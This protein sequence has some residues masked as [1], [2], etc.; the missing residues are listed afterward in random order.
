MTVR[1]RRRG[2]RPRRGQPKRPKRWSASSS[3]MVTDPSPGLVPV[4]VVDAL[5]LGDAGQPPV[6]MIL[7]GE[8]DVEDWADEQEIRVDRVVGD[9]AIAGNATQVGAPWSPICVRMGLIVVEELSDDGTAPDPTRNLFDQS[10]LQEAEWMWLH[11]TI[12]TAPTERMTSNVIPYAYNM[13]LDL[14]VRRKIGQKDG[15]FLYAAWAAETNAYDG[16]MVV[17]LRLYHHLRTIMVSK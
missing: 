3:F 8:F 6:D 12:L 10:D 5:A 2:F 11:Q 15:M 17:D 9:I 16:L 13:H 1:G 7:S 14:R 4:S